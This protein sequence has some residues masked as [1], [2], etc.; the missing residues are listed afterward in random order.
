MTSEEILQ[1]LQPWI[2]KHRRTAWFPKVSDSAGEPTGSRFGGTP[3]LPQGA[4]VPHCGRCERPL[5]MLLQLE[6]G[7]LPV[8]ARGALPAV[9]LLQA[10]YCEDP[11]CELQPEGSM[12]FSVL[13]A[14]RILS[15]SAE[16]ILAAPAEKPFPARAIVGWEPRPD[17]PS[18]AEQPDLGLSF[19][20]DFK[21]GTMRIRCP[22][23]GLE[24]PSIPLE[25]LEA[26]EISNA[27]GG[28]KLRGWPAWVQGVEYPRCPKC[29]GWMELIFQLESEKNL[30]HMWGDAGIV[31]LT[32][33]PKDPEV[34]TLGWASA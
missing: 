13:H 21:A 20:Y 29:E 11:D 32:Q 19:D 14:V 15:P 33:C 7:A 4:S 5:R 12:P 24:T 16:G 28:D 25:V 1:R 8:G 10:F 26:E 9:G 22:E 30:P 6:L 3:W 31:H 27:S 34:L 23:V 17:F 2:D 18:A